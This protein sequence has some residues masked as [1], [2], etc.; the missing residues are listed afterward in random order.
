MLLNQIVLAALTA[1][2]VALGAVIWDIHANLRQT[3]LIASAA[4]QKVSNLDGMT[5][6]RKSPNAWPVLPQARVIAMGEA[7]QGAGKPSTVTIVCDGAE[8]EDVRHDLDDAFQIAG[9]STVFG[10]SSGFFGA[11]SV[12]GILVGGKSSATLAVLVPA[13]R[14]AVGVEIAAASDMSLTT[15]VGIVI[16][17]RPR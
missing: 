3:R 16:G 14:D 11:G 7:L 13:L 5:V 17:R 6:K 4:M 2:L 15:D 12:D 10:S 8:C 9:W 1:A